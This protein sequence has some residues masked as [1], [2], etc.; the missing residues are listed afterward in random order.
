MQQVQSAVGC[1]GTALGILERALRQDDIHSAAHAQSFRE[2]FDFGEYHIHLQQTVNGKSYE[3]LRTGNQRK[4]PAEHCQYCTPASRPPVSID[5]HNII[6][7]KVR[8]TSAWRGIPIRAA[9]EKTM[10]DETTSRQVFMLY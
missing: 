5:R 4:P 6:L 8:K 2:K 1:F 10:P 7:L 3:H 9:L